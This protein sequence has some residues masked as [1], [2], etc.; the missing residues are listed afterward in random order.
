MTLRADG[1]VVVLLARGVVPCGG[2]LQRRIVVEVDVVPQPEILAVVV[3]AAV[4]VS[5]QLAEVCDGL[6]LVGIALRAITSAESTIRPRRRG[7]E[8]HHKQH[9]GCLG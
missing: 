5:G 7:R 4:H 6:Y 3:V 2:G 9:H 8:H 1:G